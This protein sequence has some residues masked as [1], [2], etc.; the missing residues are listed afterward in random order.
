VASALVLGAAAVQFLDNVAW[1]GYVRERGG[2]QGVHYSTPLA[3]QQELIRRACQ[4]SPSPISLENATVIFPHALGYVAR[5]TPACQNVALSICGPWGCPPG[6]SL[7]RVR[8]AGPVGG[9][10]VLD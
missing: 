8:Y 4:E 1:M 7:R 9:A 6:A 5:T 10:L 3:A 2:T